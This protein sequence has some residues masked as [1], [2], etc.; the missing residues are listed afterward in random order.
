VTRFPRT[1]KPR[2]ELIEEMVAIGAGDAEVQGARAWDNVLYFAGADVL[3]VLREAYMLFF[4]ANT[5][6]PT[7][8]PS[9]RRFENDILAMTADLLH[10]SSAV[11]SVTPSGSES[12]LLAVK[13]ARDWARAA[14]PAIEHPEMILPVSAF[15]GFRKAAHYLGVKPVSIPVNDDF[16]AD[17]EA[18]RSALTPSTVLIVG[19][20]PSYPQGVV[21]PIDEL[22][23]LADERGICCHVDAC[24]GGYALPF[25]SRL[26]YPVPD[27]DFRVRG[28]T[29]ISA[30]PHKFGFSARGV[31]TVLFRD[32]E[33][34][35]HQ[36]FIDPEWRGG[37]YG[38]PILTG[39]RTGGTVATA[40]A[41]MNYLGEDG[42]LRLAK[43][44]MEATLE[45]LDGIRAIPGLRV[46]GPPHMNVL[47]FASDTV[48]IYAVGEALQ[49]KN[50]RMVLQQQ[51]PSIHL[52]VTPGNSKSVQPFL[53]DLAHVVQTVS[54]LG[55]KAT[56][57]AA[58]YQQ[59]TTSSNP[60]QMAELILTFLDS[61]YSPGGGAS[62]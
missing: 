14:E 34:R 36:F 3:E 16:R 28:V 47:S 25:L 33:L 2:R 9:L 22:A 50:W 24:L 23:A 44:S 5:L 27:F 55:R 40:W 7:S 41:V 4:S 11:G 32:R 21:D 38:A 13:V 6:N 10:G 20:A 30:D 49:E 18:A 35:K 29:S 26:G 39:G 57:M 43:T 52:V 15:P 53:T 46:L 31:S 59:L 58:R 54:T 37:P 45:L 62:F 12:I 17:V 48:D 1:G 60:D 8:F 61:L 51:P 19:S 42:Y 56:G